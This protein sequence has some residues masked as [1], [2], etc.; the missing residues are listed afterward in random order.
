[1]STVYF[2]RKKKWNFWIFFGQTQTPKLP[3][4]AIPQ[5]VRIQRTTKFYYFIF[6]VRQ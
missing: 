6:V 3:N 1:M 4:Q 5:R 2:D